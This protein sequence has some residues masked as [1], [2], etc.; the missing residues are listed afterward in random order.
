M[1]PQNKDIKLW[2]EEERLIR[3]KTGVFRNLNLI[4]G[5]GGVGLEKREKK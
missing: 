5:G 2:R 4:A 1:Y 3:N